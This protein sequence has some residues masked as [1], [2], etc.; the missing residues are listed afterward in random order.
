MSSNLKDGLSEPQAARSTDRTP[1]RAAAAGVGQ[2][3]SSPTEHRQELHDPLHLLKN[4]D[5]IRFDERFQ[6]KLKEKYSKFSK[7]LT[8]LC[9][10]E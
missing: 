9:K 7:I 1:A 8:I 10:Q 2:A 4:K 3:S 5:K 6:I